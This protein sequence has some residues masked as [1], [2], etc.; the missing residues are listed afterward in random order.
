MTDRFVCGD[1]MLNED[2]GPLMS[3]CPDLKVIYAACHELVLL[4]LGGF[5][6]VIYICKR[7]L[8]HSFYP[9]NSQV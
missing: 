8:M 5:I 9:R 6:L 7:S 2:C 3:S 1:W 4:L